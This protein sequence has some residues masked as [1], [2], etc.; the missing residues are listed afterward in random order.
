[1]SVNI[2]FAEM[3]TEAL[4]TNIKGSLLLASN[5]SISFFN[6]SL[7]FLFYLLYILCFS[8]LHWFNISILISI[9]QYTLPSRKQNWQC[10]T[11]CNDYHKLVSMFAVL[12]GLKIY[13]R[14]NITI[15][16]GIMAVMDFVYINLPQLDRE[17][18]LYVCMVT[19]CILQLSSL[20]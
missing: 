11:V 1:M 15:S 16:G 8:D 7:F 13:V 6:S 5:I 2:L 3:S 14:G 10:P 18:K 20:H 12:K 19:M 4:Q 9:F 17:M